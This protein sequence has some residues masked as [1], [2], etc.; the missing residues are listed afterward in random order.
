MQQ[1]LR[2]NES[3]VYLFFYH[4]AILIYEKVYILFIT[5]YMQVGL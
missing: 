5:F 4:L 2:G 3:Q 1:K